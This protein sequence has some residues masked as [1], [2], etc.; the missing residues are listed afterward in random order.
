MKVWLG[1]TL[2]S[3]VGNDKT[4]MDGVKGL[5]ESFLGLKAH[6]S[7]SVLAHHAQGPGLI[8]CT[9]RG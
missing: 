7:D 3:A 4:L 6:I 9:A 5:S 8:V 1:R 2:H